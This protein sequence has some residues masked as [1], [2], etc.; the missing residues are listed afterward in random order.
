M[1]A[2]I[3]YKT[4]IQMKRKKIKINGLKIEVE[5]YFVELADKW[6]LEYF[7][8]DK[9]MKTGYW[10]GEYKDKPTKKYMECQAKKLYN[11]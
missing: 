8:E 4:E 6:I 2:N 7:L 3:S 5:Y 11:L 1:K 9:E 10:C